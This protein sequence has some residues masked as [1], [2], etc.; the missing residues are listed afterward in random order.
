MP[1][2]IAR[3]MASRVTV[4]GQRGQHGP[5]EEH[6]SLAQADGKAEQAESDSGWNVR[7]ARPADQHAEAGSGERELVEACDPGAGRGV[8]ARSQT[9][10]PR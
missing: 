1:A 2:A 10:R 7:I 8:R 5:V 9:P 3:A 6:L 4:A